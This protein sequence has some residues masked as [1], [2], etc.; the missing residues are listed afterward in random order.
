MALRHKLTIALALLT[1]P[2]ALSRAEV[3]TP[4][5]EIDRPETTKADREYEEAIRALREA[6]FPTGERVENWDV[7]GADLFGAVRVM[8]AEKY[9]VLET[10][11]SDGSAML[12][13]LTPSPIADFAP[14]SWRI[15]KSYGSQETRLQD[16]IVTFG[17]LSS[18]FVLA[19]RAASWRVRDVLCGDRIGHAI[20]YEVPDAPRSA[21]D[22]D[23][24]DMFEALMLATEGQTM[25]G[26]YDGD[27]EKGYTTRA[28]LPEGRLLLNPDRSEHAGRATI[29][30]A[31]PVDRLIKPP[32]EAPATQP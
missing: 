5:G 4:L 17:Y 21:G 7:G 31:A 28:F 15:V 20:L 19:G 6:M 25:C 11:A 16:P 8:G 13:I 29:V 26:R 18:R 9:Y 1:T 30:P 22:K 14:A 32:I 3:P 24:V 12:S 23:I 27:P 2:C 10:D